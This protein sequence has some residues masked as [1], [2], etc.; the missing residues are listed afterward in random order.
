MDL[1]H[2][3]ATTVAESGAPLA[4]LAGQV[5]VI[6]T[7]PPYIPA[8][9]VPRDPEVRDHE[10]AMALYGGDDGLDTVRGILRTAALLLKPGGLVV[11]EHADIQAKAITEL[12][13]AAGWHS[14]TS[15]QDFNGRD[16]V[17]TAIR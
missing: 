7:N 1:V 17:V 14:V 10:P 9:M 16:R 12:L 6:V 8:L 11:I 15:H 4:R 3:D 13:L 5:A 2:H